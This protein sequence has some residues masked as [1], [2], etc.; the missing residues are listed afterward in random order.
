MTWSVTAKGAAMAVL[1]SI[2]KQT[3]A[4]LKNLEEIKAKEE[5]IIKAHIKAFMQFLSAKLSNLG[6]ESHVEVTA[7][8]HKAEGMV[9]ELDLKIRQV[10]PPVAAAVEADASKVVSEVKTVAGEAEKAAETVVQG[11][12]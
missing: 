8:G 2:E 6:S 12:A 1:A 7:V 11:N 3:E 5:P 4:V 9:H 10:E